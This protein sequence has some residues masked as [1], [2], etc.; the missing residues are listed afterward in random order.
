MLG[1]VTV[2]AA[3]AVALAVAEPIAHGAATGAAAAATDAALLCLCFANPRRARGA[4]VAAAA[5]PA[6]A[7]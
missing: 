5:A 2:L 7:P 1:A 6:A 3:A 4:F